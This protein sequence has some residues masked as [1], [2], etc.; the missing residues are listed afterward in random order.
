MCHYAAEE[1]LQSRIRVC[2]NDLRARDLAC[3][4]SDRLIQ[5]GCLTDLLTDTTR[6]LS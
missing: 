3:I 2:S 1:F 4:Q 6:G 5:F